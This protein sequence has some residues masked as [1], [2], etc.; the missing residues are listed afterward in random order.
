MRK[1]KRN[2]NM[3]EAVSAADFIGMTRDELASAMET[4][5]SSIIK[6]TN[7]WRPLADGILHLIASS[8]KNW[9]K[10]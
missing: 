1:Q 5:Y 8:R 6:E 2:K 10:L 9:Q 4:G 3:N 7:D